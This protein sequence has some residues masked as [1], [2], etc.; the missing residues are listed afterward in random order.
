MQVPLTVLEVRGH[1]GDRGAVRKVPGGN[2]AF[3]KNECETTDGLG[4]KRS[5]PVRC[6]ICGTSGNSMENY[7]SSQ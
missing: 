4:W 3:L 6:S 2:Q 5:I 7:R 1:E